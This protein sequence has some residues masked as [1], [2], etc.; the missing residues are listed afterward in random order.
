LDLLMRFNL[1]S[2]YADLLNQPYFHPSRQRC[3]AATF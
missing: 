3:V 2:G 1:G